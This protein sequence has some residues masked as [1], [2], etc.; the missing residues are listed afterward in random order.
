LGGEK[1]V[2][3]RGVTHLRPLGRGTST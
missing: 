1:T 3:E 2:S